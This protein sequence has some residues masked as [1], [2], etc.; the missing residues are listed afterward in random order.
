MA[1]FIVSDTSL[2]SHQECEFIHQA[3][4]ETR[5]CAQ[6][7]SSTV[8]EGSREREIEQNCECWVLFSSIFILMRRN[9]SRKPVAEHLGHSK[10]APQ[11]WTNLLRCRHGSA[12]QICSG[13][14]VS[15]PHHVTMQYGHIIKTSRHAFNHYVAKPVSVGR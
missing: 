12:S 7:S 6:G 9:R 15:G 1:H 14:S 13:Q 10:L 11:P 4:I 2:T 5:I 8:G 3:F